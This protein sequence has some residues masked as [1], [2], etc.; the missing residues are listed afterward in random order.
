MV[1]LALNRNSALAAIGAARVGGD[2]V[3]VGS[4]S[5]SAE[6][7]HRFGS[8]GVNVTMFNHALS[9]VDAAVLEDALASIAEH[10]PGEVIWVQHAANP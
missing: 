4:D 6:E 5:L 8:E 9:G 7:H 2:A 10:H 1:Y 3:W